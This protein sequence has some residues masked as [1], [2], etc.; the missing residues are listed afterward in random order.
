ASQNDNLVDYLEEA[1]LL[2]EDRTDDDEEPGFG[3]KL[4][5]VHASKGLEF[6]AVFIAGCEETL[7]PHWRSMDSVKGL[8]EERRLMY[9]ALTRAEKYLYLSWAHYRKGEYHQQSRFFDEVRCAL[10]SA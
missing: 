2:K 5:T 6:Q 10:D 3:V 7:F 4:S 8:Q 9:V 1:A